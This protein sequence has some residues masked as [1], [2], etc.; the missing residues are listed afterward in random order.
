MVK[1]SVVDQMVWKK[2]TWLDGQ[3]DVQF[4][5]N[6]GAGVPTAQSALPLKNDL[7]FGIRVSVNF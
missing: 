2:S 1:H 4:V 5:V 3:P 6:S 7:I